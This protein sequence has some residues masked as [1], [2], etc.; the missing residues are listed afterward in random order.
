MHTQFFPTKKENRNIFKRLCI[1]VLQRNRTKRIHRD[2]SKEIYYEELS[3]VIIEHWAETAICWLKAGGPGKLEA[4]FQSKL[5]GLT[6][7]RADTQGQEKTISQLE[8]RGQIRPSSTFSFYLGPQWMG[9]H[10]LALVRESS[11]LILPI[12][13]LVYS[14]NTLMD[15][16]RDN[17]LLAIWASVSR[18]KLTHKINHQRS[19]QLSGKHRK[20]KE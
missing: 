9:W 7:R 3:Q 5:E 8:E 1:R 13:I 17:V 14:G 12:Q 11:L 19:P 2:I 15:T 18:I 4:Y 16:R 20:E 6:T 10:P